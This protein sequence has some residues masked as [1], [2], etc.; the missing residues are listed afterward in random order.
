MKEYQLPDNTNLK[1]V[2]NFSVP[3]KGDYVDEL[4]GIESFF[5]NDRFDTKFDMFCHLHLI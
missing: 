2:V 4:D 5:E 1:S 3:Q